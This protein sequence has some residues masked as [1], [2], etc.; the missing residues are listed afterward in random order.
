MPFLFPMDI[1]QSP[2]SPETYPLITYAFVFGLSI[3]GGV[4][5]FMQKLKRGHARAWN[6]AEFIG[7][8]ATSAFAG[9]ITFYLCQWSG[10]SPLLTA[11]FVGISGHMG[12]RAIAIMER[13][14]ESKF[15]EIKNNGN[16][17][18]PT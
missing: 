11:S 2:P 1:N 8:L 18:T 12:S 5:S 3:L 16:N 9:V 17:G 6:V 15:G 4:V 10:F 14:F 7:E 13:F